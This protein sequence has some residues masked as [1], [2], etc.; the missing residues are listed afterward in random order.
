MYQLNLLN[1]NNTLLIN[2][3]GFRANITVQEFDIIVQKYKSLNELL[4]SKLDFNFK[5]LVISQLLRYRA[6]IFMTSK[7][8]GQRSKDWLCS[9]SQTFS[10]F[11][12]GM[13]HC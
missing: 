5:K 3:N 11:F 13:L 7:N 8:V 9:E 10:A 12:H 4:K 2:N 6:D 1:N